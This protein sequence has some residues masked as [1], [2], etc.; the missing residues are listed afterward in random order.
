MFVLKKLLQ[1]NIAKNSMWMLFGQGLRVLIQGVY[2]VLI[3]RLLGVEEYGAFISVIALVAIIAP[4]C[5][6]GTGNLMIRNVA[7][8]PSKFQTSWGKAILITLISGIGFL[9]LLLILK[10][11]FFDSGISLILVI[12]I[13]LADMLFARLLDISGQAFQAFHQLSWT[14]NFNVL[15]SLMRLL[16]AFNLFYLSPSAETLA[17]MYLLSTLV[18][19]LIAMLIVTKKL[20]TPCLDK[21]S[22]FREKLDG[23]YFAVGLSTQNVYNDIDK[24]MLSKVSSFE[25]A[26]LYAAGYRIIDVAFT[27]VRSLMYATYSKFFVNG[28]LGIGNSI[29]FAKKILPIPVI[30]S[31]I[32]AVILYYSAP[33]LPYVLGEDFRKTISVVQFLAIVPLIKVFQYFAGDILTGAG[34]Q[35]TRTFVQIFTAILNIGLNIWLLPLYSYNGAILTTLITDMVL[36]T[37]LCAFVYINYKKELTRS[38]E[39]GL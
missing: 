21:N 10:T 26:G 15:I 4:F 14:A 6:L 24:A 19:S 2:F 36:A 11:I 34:Y 35:G 17:L 28:R 12:Y 23:L 16:A 39:I 31:I 1:N 27:P 25:A 33:L 30:Y 5:S 13:A 18:S 29:K 9:L 22:L 20:G 37:L 8:S 32:A 3:A 38:S 7:E